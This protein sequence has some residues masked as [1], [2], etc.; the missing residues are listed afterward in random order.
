[1]QLIS[2]SFLFLSQAQS[3]QVDNVLTLPDFNYASFLFVLI[4]NIIV[5]FAVIRHSILGGC[6]LWRQSLNLLRFKQSSLA[7]R[8]SKLLDCSH[9][10]VKWVFFFQLQL[11]LLLILFKYSF[12]CTLLCS[13]IL[14][15]VIF[16]RFAFWRKEVREIYSYIFVQLQMSNSL[17]CRRPLSFFSFLLELLK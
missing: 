7:E 3:F 6:L 14:V 10:H 17:S 5:I 2:D 8:S 16:F 11:G 4:D 12:E 1:M 15:C 9:G 13:S